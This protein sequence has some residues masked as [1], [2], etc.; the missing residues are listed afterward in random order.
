VTLALRDNAGITAAVENLRAVRAAAE[1]RRGALQPRVEAR[2]RSGVG[3][4]FDGIPDQR[5][6]TTAELVLNWTLYSGGGDQARIR[7]AVNLQARAADLRDKTC[8][9][10]RQTTAIA[11]SDIGKL[12]D[13]QAALER[14]TLSIEKAREAYRKQFD[15][16]MRTLLDL[17]NAENEVYTARRALA[18]AGFDLT[19]AQMRTL[20][21]TQRLGALLGA[22][23][24]VPVPP[25]AD[26]A[27]P[28]DLPARCPVEVVQLAP[29]PL[30]ALDAQARDL[31]KSAPPML[32]PKRP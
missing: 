17:L 32:T 6:D 26:D 11:Y 24:P 21:G 2:L 25:G 22:A 23:V 15:I 12:V 31:L 16:G 10:V 9:D 19:L 20:A 8:R 14:N 4:N 28:A 29:V 3:N 30:Q 27:G 1:A 5:H 13:L 7:E 18:N